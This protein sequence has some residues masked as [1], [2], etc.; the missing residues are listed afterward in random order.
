ML[1]VSPSSSARLIA[2]PLLLLSVLLPSPSGFALCSLFA[3][4][5]AAAVA[6]QPLFERPLCTLVPAVR[7]V[8][9]NAPWSDPRAESVEPLRISVLLPRDRWRVCV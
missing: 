6:A 9:R 2:V 8:R 5:S 1:G 7:S 4:L 3:L